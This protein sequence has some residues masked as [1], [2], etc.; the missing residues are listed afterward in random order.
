M[1]EDLRSIG[2]DLLSNV[3]HQL[4]EAID[5]AR[6][7]ASLLCG[8]AALAVATLCPA[9][10][11]SASTLVT[12]YNFC[13]KASC[14]DGSQPFGGVIGDAAGTLYGTTLHG[15]LPGGRNNGAYGEGTVFAVTPKGTETVLHSFNF[16][17]DR[18]DGL[19]AW[20]GLIIDRK[21]NLFGTTLSGGETSLGSG[22]GTVFEIPAGGSEQTIYQFCALAECTDGHSPAGPVIMDAKGNLY[23]TTGLHGIGGPRNGGVVFE[24]SPNAAGTAWKQTVLFTFPPNVS[25]SAGLVMDASGDLFGTTGS[26]HGTVF[27][28]RHSSGNRWKS[29]RF[30][31]FAGNRNA[32][33]EPI[34]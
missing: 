24:L 14:L 16:S 8:A 22:W 28:L 2:R 1:R 30:M 27:E 25:P 29:K 9:S 7:S 12:L 31:P 5:G 11:H 32:P 3:G 13:A 17:R 19:G 10:G 20:Y 34:P 15:G 21:G 18:H 6:Y 26:G 33:M 23:G 4:I